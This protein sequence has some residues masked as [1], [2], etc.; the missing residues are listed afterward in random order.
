M[1]GEVHCNSCSLAFLIVRSCLS[2][3][4]PLQT[5]LGAGAA[6]ATTAAAFGGALGM[7]V[8]TVGTAR[9]DDSGT[10]AHVPMGGCFGCINW[11]GCFGISGAHVP[12]GSRPAGGCPEG[13]GGGSS[14]WM[15]A[16]AILSCCFVTIS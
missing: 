12:L 2:L 9:A 6:R 5:T 13:G 10:G 3:Q 4:N 15:L 16:A 8:G 14:D 7:C 1:P 11:G